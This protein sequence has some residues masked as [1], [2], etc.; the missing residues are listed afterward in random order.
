MGTRHGRL[1]LVLFSGGWLGA[2]WL[3]LKAGVDAP[4]TG[5]DLLIGLFAAGYL[6]AW[7][8]FF[9]LS[10]RGPLG[11]AARFVACS[12]SIAV[13]LAALEVPVLIRLV[14][15]RLVFAT[16][17]S[18]WQRPG[19]RPDPDLIYVRA[20]QQ[21]TRLRFRGGDL[22]R[23]RGA[24]SA[25]IYEC[26]LRLDRNGF[27][28]P[29]DLPRADVV[30]LG[31]SFIE[32][33]QVT[34]TDLVTAQLA[35]RLQASV[36][37]L[38]RTGYGPQQELHV[39]RRYGLGLRPKVCVWAFYEGN[40]LQDVATYDDERHR[41][42]QG[43][44]DS[45]SREWYYRSLMRNGL[46][47]LLRNWLRP[48]PTS[49]A[50]RQAGRFVARF[51]RPVD[52]YFSC[53]VHEGAAL[54]AARSDSAELRHTRSIL[55]E[56]HA[57]CRGAGIDLV[58]AFVPAKFRVYRDFC[59][60]EANSPCR[61]W[62]VDDLPAALKHAV[63]AISDE[64]GFLDLTTR[65]RAEAAAGSL[66]YLTDDTHWSSEGHRAAADALAD[67]LARRRGAPRSAIANWPR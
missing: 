56:A 64:I 4:E 49:P 51:G 28:N 41:A 18:P 24:P 53:G 48:D 55:A 59:T 60:F 67:F 57:A 19:N 23:L 34:A 39:L 32:G 58:V 20:G 50:S 25:P 65:L 21:Q 33:L 16:P 1:A 62:D 35:D 42:C 10:R 29:A 14:D 8:P 11:R 44:P 7:G 12:A 66:P 3:A 2:L 46:D 47:Y 45:F 37:N 31:D 15:Y 22:H 17:V 13:G 36:V 27:R 30:V 40:D 38:G 61:S 26:D 5:P 43:K 63:A 52:I 9:L 6:A 54:P